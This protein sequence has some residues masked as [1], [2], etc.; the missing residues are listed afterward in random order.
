MKI[1]D[2]TPSYINEVIIQYWLMG[3]TR[4]EI[5]QEFHI[6]TGT[7]SNIWAEF[8]NKLDHYEVDTLRELG[9]HL[10]RQNMTAE[11]CAKGSRVSKILEK[12]GI[13]EEEMEVFL[14][15][16]YEMSQKMSIYPETLKDVLIQFAQISDKVPFSELP[17]KQLEEEIENR[18]KKKEEKEEQVRSALRQANTTQFHLDMFVNTKN[19]LEE[20]YSIHVED[21]DKFTKCV[22]GIKKYSNY[23]PFKV[24]EKFSDREKLEKEVESKQKEENDL[25]INIKRLK[26]KEFQYDDRLNLK[27]IKLKNLEE[28]ERIG[29]TNQDLKKL[30]NILIEIAIEYKITNKEQIKA[31]FFELFEKLEDRIAFESKNNSLLKTSLIL[32]NQVRVKRQILHCQE[33]VGPILK[34]LFVNGI[35]ETEIVA[36]KA[37]IDIL[38]YIF[39][40]T[41]NN[42]ANTDIKYENFANLSINNSNSNWRKEYEKLKESLISNLILH[43]VLKVID[44]I[45]YAKDRFRI[46][47]STFPSIPSYENSDSNDRKQEGLADTIIEDNDSI[48]MDNDTIIEDKDIVADYNIYIHTPGSFLTNQ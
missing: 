34:N 21:I 31:K 22:H 8:R 4:D 15:T 37:F 16:N 18:K 2:F 24:I 1:K 44:K 32:E 39:S 47:Y 41:K 29:F 27:S 30:I 12:Y 35:T 26:E 23:D 17:K 43:L 10:R 36:V 48:I 9:K 33:V 42:I 7:A 14:T 45:Q 5:A 13:P 6:S 11:S 20:K 19:E 3:Y 25:E 46:Y 38:S 40:T 28:L